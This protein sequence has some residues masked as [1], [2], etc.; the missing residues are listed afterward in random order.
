M[1]WVIGWWVCMLV[2]SLHFPL[3]ALKTV[4]GS[5]LE[6]SVVAATLTSACF[7]ILNWVTEL[8][9]GVWVCRVAPDAAFSIW[10]PAIIT[11]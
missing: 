4:D 5:C 3:L 9:S 1:S 10:V 2:W 8:P 7:R 6:S 11:N